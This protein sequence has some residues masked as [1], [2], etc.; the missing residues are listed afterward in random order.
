MAYETIDGEKYEKEL[1][2]LARK[3]TTGKGEGRI[4]KDEAAELIESAKD[5]T[6]V[7]ETEM[8]TLKYIRSNFQF[9]DAA[10]AQFDADVAKL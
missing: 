5:G 1:L 3:H 4:S 2:E 7:T 10:A 9:T 6:S 8:K